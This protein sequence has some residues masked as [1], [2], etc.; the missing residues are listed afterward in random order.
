VE[1]SSTRETRLQGAHREFFSTDQG[2]QIPCS[3]ENREFPG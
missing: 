2:I 1:P 3:G